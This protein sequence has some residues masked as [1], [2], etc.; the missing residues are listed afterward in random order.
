[1]EV[2]SRPAERPFRPLPA[3]ALP[4]IVRAVL[5]NMKPASPTTMP[6]RTRRRPPPEDMPAVRSNPTTDSA[7]PEAAVGLAP[8]LVTSLPARAAATTPVR[9]EEHTSELQSRQ[10]L[11]CRLLLEKKKKIKQR[12]HGKAILKVNKYIIQVQ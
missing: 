4:A 10:Y 7:R 6:E 8:S 9:S 1:M 2:F 5:Q 3:P 11:V 12:I